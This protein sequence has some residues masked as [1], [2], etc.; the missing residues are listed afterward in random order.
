MEKVGIVFSPQY[1]YVRGRQLEGTFPGN[2]WTGIWVV[3]V[4]RIGHGWGSLPEQVWAYDT[5]IWPPVEPAGLDAIADDDCAHV[6][7]PSIVAVTV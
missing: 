2:R 4:M 6:V 3:T 5:S 1:A 7:L